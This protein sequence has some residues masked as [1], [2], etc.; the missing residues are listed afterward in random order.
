MRSYLSSRIAARRMLGSSTGLAEAEDVQILVL[1]STRWQMYVMFAKENGNK[2]VPVSRRGSQRPSL[3]SGCMFRA[4]ARRTSANQLDLFLPLR[5][6]RQ[7]IQVVS[8]AVREKSAR[9][10]EVGRL[11]KSAAGDHK[12]HGAFLGGP[13]GLWACLTANLQH[14]WAS[15]NSN[16]VPPYSICIPRVLR[17]GRY[18]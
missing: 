3:I 5:D 9:E 4:K 14:L 7:A 18:S 8:K 10:V 6:V 17:L 15:L 11:A 16:F 12:R 13:F 2:G 1:L